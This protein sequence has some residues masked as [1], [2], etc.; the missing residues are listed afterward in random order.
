MKKISIILLLISLKSFSASLIVLIPGAASSGD[1][2]SVRGLTPVFGPIKEGEY[3]K[4][5]NKSLN[6]AGFKTITCPKLRDRDTRDINQRAFDCKSFLLKYILQ[7]PKVKF[8]LIGHSMG[9]LV[10]RKLID[11]RLFSRFVKTVTTISTPH[12]GAE[13][14]NLAIDNH[15]KDSLVGHFVRLIEFTPEKR[16][17]LEQLRSVNGES[18]YSQKLKNPRKIPVYSISNYKTNYYNGPLS[19]SERYISQRNDGII[20]T[21]SMIFGEHLGTIQADHMESGC[22][23]YTKRSK[24]C[25]K[26]LRILLTHLNR[27]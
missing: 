22:I 27:L 3:F 12:K 23:L 4:F 19:I 7:N 6:N 17:Y 9:G 21:S 11:N 10:A 5:L 25:K 16:K 8:H 13:L 14:A 1:Q 18:P 2:I 15:L 24:G 26:V 20:E